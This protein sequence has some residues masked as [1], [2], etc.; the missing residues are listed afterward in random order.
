M[1][2][3][4]VK[5]TMTWAL[6]DERDEFE[7]AYAGITYYSVLLDLD[8]HLRT[9]IKYDDSIP[10]SLKDGYQ[11]LRAWLHERCSEEGIEL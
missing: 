8:H 10:D 11:E 6:P 4:A 5:I 7:K 3:R 1:R 9:R 2:R